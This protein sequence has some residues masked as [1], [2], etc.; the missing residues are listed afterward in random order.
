MANVTVTVQDNGGTD[1][2]GVNTVS[3]LFKLTVNAAAT[4]T[5]SGTT[6]VPLNST[7]RVVTFNGANGIAPYTFTYNING[8]T[9]RTVTTTSGNSVTVSA[10]TNVAGTFS[11]NLV[12][13][14]DANCGQVQTGTATITIWPLP[15]AT[16]SGTSAVCL[17]GNSPTIT[18][19]GSTG[20]APYTFTYN[21]N[22]GTTR[23]A[24]TTSGN[25][26]TLTAPSNVAGTFTYN[27]VSVADANTSQLQT[28]SAI[29]TINPLPIITIT[30]TTPGKV[31][32]GTSVTLAA[33]GAVNYTWSPS[34]DVISGQG[35]AN[36]VVRPKQ[37]TVYTVT[38]TNASGCVSTQFFQV[39]IEEDYKIKPLNILTPNG[40]GKND[41]F[42][43]DNIDYYPNNTLKVFDR[44]G[45]IVYTAKSYKNDWD[46]TYNGSAL[47]S[48]TYYYVVD[49]GTGIRQ[50]KGYITLIRN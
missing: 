20:T 5:I 10:P 34:M 46:G 35:T 41:K 31:S 37:S 30:S 49:F 26:V 14:T 42:I 43:I 38:G 17:N 1:F 33:T 23:T 25:T 28:G 47:A 29:I 22:G 24:T 6:A 50:F 18:F 15:V 13:V 8:G 21:I 32:K 11:Y 39:E 2:G 4:A 48:D 40:D 27:L 9:T 3:T 44:S 16:I 45:R 36:L 12:N 19:T 7:A